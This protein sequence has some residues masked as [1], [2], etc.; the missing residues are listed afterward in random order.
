MNRTKCGRHQKIGTNKLDLV[1]DMLVVCCQ[2]I[3]TKVGEHSYVRDTSKPPSTFDHSSSRCSHPSP[4]RVA[5]ALLLLITLGWLVL[6]Q[7]IVVGTS[8][9]WVQI[10]VGWVLTLLIVLHSP[11]SSLPCSLAVA[12]CIMLSIVLLAII[13]CWICRRQ[14]HSLVL[15]LTHCRWRAIPH[16]RRGK[17]QKLGWRFVA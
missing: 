3:D 8:C 7:F 11:F 16:P 2:S 14:P 6:S 17:G 5:L 12:G 13:G 10:V 15:S 9:R 1:F 4:H